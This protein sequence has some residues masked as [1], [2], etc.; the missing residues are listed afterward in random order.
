VSGPRLAG[1]VAV[2]TGAGSRGEGI[3]NG[4][5]AAVL[6]A[7]EG[8]KVLLVD[9]TQ[10][11][12]A[13]TLEMIRGEKGEAE[14]FEADVTRSA[15]C[16][17]MVADAVR[18]WGRLDIL[19]N[20]VGIGGRATV[21]DVDEAEWDHLMKVNVT[22][23]MLTS[24]HAIPAMA[25][26]GSGAIVNISSISA[27]RPRGL[28]PYSVSKGAVIALTRAMAID[29]APQGIRVNCIAPGP[30][31][32]PMVYAGGMSADLRERRRR[33]S[34]LNVEGTGWDIGYAALFLCSDEARYIT[35]VVLPVDGGVTITSAGR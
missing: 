21:V 31:Y 24:K 11:A 2:V 1:K 34:P 10:K 30:V 25:K 6:F 15:D 27:L 35:G 5:A 29:H 16:E 4:R 26:N 22:S 12:A 32:T 7:R 9:Q 3:G 17:A 13:E 18:R 19:D 23:M 8:A 33:A 14:I 20:N 28:T